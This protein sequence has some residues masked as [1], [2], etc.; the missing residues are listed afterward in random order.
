MRGT[1]IKRATD[2]SA[3][4]LR[5]ADGFEVRGL[6]ATA[7]GFR[8]RAKMLAGTALANCLTDERQPVVDNRSDGQKTADVMARLSALEG[9]RC[10]L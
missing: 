10:E 5:D 4:L 3:R 9:P 6:K 8:Q 1:D 2:E 7:A